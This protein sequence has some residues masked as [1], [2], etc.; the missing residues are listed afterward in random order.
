MTPQSTLVSVGDQ[1]A[2]PK[3]ELNA[4][5]FKQFTEATWLYDLLVLSKR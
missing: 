1:V 4:A 2:W 5:V 3:F